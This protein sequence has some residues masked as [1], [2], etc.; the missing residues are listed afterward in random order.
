MGSGS[1]ISADKCRSEKVA[2]GLGTARGVTQRSLPERGEHTSTQVRA[3]RRSQAAASELDWAERGLGWAARDGN[4]SRRSIR[5]SVRHIR[6]LRASHQLVGA[7]IGWS[8]H[9]VRSSTR[10]I[11]SSAHRIRRSA[12]HIGSSTRDIRW[13]ALHVICLTRD[14]NLSARHTNLRKR[15]I[16][17]SEI[18]TV[19]S[20]HHEIWASRHG[21]WSAR[22]VR[23]ITRG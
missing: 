18:L 5:R 9:H 7:P 19:C 22:R 14:I 21:F 23:G 6:W 8:M 2:P 11:P 16:R 4:L 10:H 12:G 15:D 3:T 17:L 1:R 13:W 20:A